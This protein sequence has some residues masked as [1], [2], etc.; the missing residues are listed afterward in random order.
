LIN[1]RKD[2]DV[3]KFILLGIVV[4][5]GGFT[6]WVRFAPVTVA[7]WHVALPTDTRELEG[8]CVDGVTALQPGGATAACSVPGTA[9][10]LLARLDAIAMATPRTRRIAGSVE[11]GRIT[12]ETRSQLWGFPDYTTAQAETR[13][14]STRLDMAARQRFGQGDMGV[15]AAR[16]KLWLGQL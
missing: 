4:L 13:G 8:S 2:A 15:N 11:E 7:T 9:P 10:E 14:A 6:L 1:I 16:L 3:L 5:V 12:W